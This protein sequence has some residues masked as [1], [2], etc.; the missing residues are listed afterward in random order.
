MRHF[1]NIEAT[2]RVKKYQAFDKIHDN[3]TGRNYI[4]F[5][6]L[7]KWF[8]KDKMDKLTKMS[9]KDKRNYITSDKALKRDGIKKQR[10]SPDGTY[11]G[12]VAHETTA[13]END[14]DKNNQ[15]QS[16]DWNEK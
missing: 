3:Y 15:Q 9:R 10:L 6:D 1:V 2:K 7:L 16:L 5:P 8:K 12:L 14:K 13:N 11:N 4:L